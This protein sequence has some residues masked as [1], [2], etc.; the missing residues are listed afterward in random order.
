M[1]SRFTERV[2]MTLMVIGFI[3]SAGYALSSSHV[4]RGDAQAGQTQA[5]SEN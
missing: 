4:H 2:M 3:L 1:D 5:S